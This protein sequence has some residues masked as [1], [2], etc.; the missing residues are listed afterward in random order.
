MSSRSHS[1]LDAVWT[2]RSGENRTERRYLDVV[3]DGVPLSTMGLGDVISPFGWL[4]HAEED[5][6]SARLLQRSSPDLP[7]GRVSLYVCPECSDLACGAVSILVERGS[8]TVTWSD[9]A[10]QNDYD[11]EIHRTGFEEIGPFIFSENAYD[12]FFESLREGHALRP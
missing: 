5:R 12:R 2:V 8:G 6:A 10:F 3:I 1:A 9:F 11:G 4:S 7:Q